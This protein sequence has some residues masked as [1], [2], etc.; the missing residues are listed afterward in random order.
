VRV[1]V[2][3]IDLNK[4]TRCGD[5]VEQCATNAVALMNNKV[6]IVRPEDCNYCTDCEAIC[7]SG[8]IRCPFEI[9]LVKVT[10]DYRKTPL[11]E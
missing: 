2:P 10:P 11:E 7:P 5:C 1:A 4:C 3:E 9:M 6:A 8:A